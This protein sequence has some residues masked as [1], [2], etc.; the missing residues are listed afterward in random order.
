MFRLALAATAC[1]LAL[2]TAAQAQVVDSVTGSASSSTRIDTTTTKSGAGTGTVTDGA[3]NTSNY[4]SNVAIGTTV[5]SFES[6][7]SLSGSSISSTSTS[8]ID[9]TIG[10]TSDVRIA[11]T[12]LSQITAAGMGVYVGDNSSG[13]CFTTG[14]AQ[15][16]DATTFQSFAS[17][18]NG[19]PLARTSVDFQVLQD[20]QT[21]YETRG[22][23]EF[24]ANGS[25]FIANNTGNGD[26]VDGANALNTLNGFV[27]LN[28]FGTLNS[29][30]IST[31]A[32]GFA[33]DATNIGVTL[34]SILGGATSTV[35]YIVT[36]SSISNANCIGTD[37]LVAY[38]GFGDPIGRGGG[39]SSFASV[40]RGFNLASTTTNFINGVNFTP[41]TFVVPGFDANG[42]LVL[43]PTGPGGIP[44]P[45]TWMSMILG[46]G[47]I[48]AALRRR[49]LPAYT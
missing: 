13:T 40:F 49:R 3:T 35:S 25:V 9:M 4:T 37:C 39:T 46:F 16:R 19:F 21:V 44:E 7:N 15:T 1:A 47:F 26:F 34:N 11:P 42:D 20:N 5:I 22:S 10:N 30:G 18:S 36:V 8:R 32:L 45:A 14:C 17:A 27:T 12:L 38:S 23:L 29:D 28:K 2:G 31:S 43:N 48:G 33:W 41:S 24:D 6:G